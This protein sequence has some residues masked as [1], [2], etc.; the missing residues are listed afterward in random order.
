MMR[1]G[2]VFFFDEGIDR[3]AAAT[4]CAAVGTL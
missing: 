2:E 4:F 1:E 3:S